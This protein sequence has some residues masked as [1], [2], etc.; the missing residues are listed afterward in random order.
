[1]PTTDNCCTIV[2]YFEVPPDKLEQFKSIAERCVERT[3]SESGCLYY[4]FSFNGNVAHCRE[5]YADGESALA[6]LENIAPLLQEALAIAKLTR[7]E[8]HGP[9]EELAKLREPMAQLKPQFFVLECG[10]RR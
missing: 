2:P 4:G 5:G 9:A 8:V 6:H 3:R 10:F 1:M 7:L